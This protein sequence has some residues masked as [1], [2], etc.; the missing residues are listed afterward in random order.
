M[1]ER[2]A[3]L[4]EAGV[5]PD[6]DVEITEAD[7]DRIVAGF[8]EAPVKVEHEDTPFDGV[9]GTLKRIWRRGRELF[10]SIAFT[11]EA[12]Q[13]IDLARARRLSVAISRDKSAITEVSLVRRPRVAGAVVFSTGEVGSVDGEPTKGGNCMN[14][15]TVEPLDAAATEGGRL[16]ACITNET[17]AR[18]EAKNSELEF[19]LSVRDAQ[20]KVD[21]L[22][23]AGKLVPAAESFARAILS[24]GGGAS[25]TFG[26]ETVS[27]AQLFERFMDAMP[28][29]IEF[30]EKTEAGSPNIGFSD[31]ERAVFAKLG[32]SEE[33]AAQI[34]GGNRIDVIR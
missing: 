26:E 29:V 8:V 21:A 13:L 14:Q 22:K 15:N 24:A 31:A 25:I 2:E 10:G 1:I 27:A 30:G 20:A 32:V 11:T 7:L 5:Y 12:W 9:L 18:L 6:K 4:F 16:E 34:V 17:L 33:K 23:R 28:K 19:K 3:K